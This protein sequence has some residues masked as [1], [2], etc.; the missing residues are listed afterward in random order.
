MSVQYSPLRFD[1]N[2]KIIY[3][4]VRKPQRVRVPCD[5]IPSWLGE[6]SCDVC[7][8]KC[9][10]TENLSY[11]PHGRNALECKSSLSCKSCIARSR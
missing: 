11:C 8:Q 1:R 2:G 5:D 7:P 3:G 10:V 4:S 9:V 6:Q